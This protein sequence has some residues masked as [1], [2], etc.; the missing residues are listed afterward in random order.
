MRDITRN[1]ISTLA[2]AGM[3]LTVGCL[4]GCGKKTSE[5]ENLT[6]EVIE[7]PVK[8]RRTSVELIR[9]YLTFTGSI[10]AVQRAAIA[11]AMP[12]KIQ[13]IFVEEGQ[14]VSKGT[15]LV[16]MDD[17]QLI[18]AESRYLT[19]KADYERMRALRDNGSITPQQLEQIEAG[20]TAAKAAWEMTMQS[21]ILEAPFSG[22]IIGKYYNNEEIYSGMKPTP[23][24]TGA[25]VSLAQL[26][27]MKIEVNVPERDFPKISKG[28][29]ALVEL[30]AYPDRVFEGKVTGI[31]AAL[32][33]RSRAAKV[34]VE[35]RN[36]G[37]LLKPGMF[38]KI[39]IIM[40]EKSNALVVPSSAI[41][42]RE[43]EKSVFVVANGTSPFSTKTT[44][45]KVTTGIVTLDYSEITFGIAKG[46][47]VVYEGNASLDNGTN[48]RVIEVTE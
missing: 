42:S 28:Q 45:K 13:R 48:V 14:T 46:D 18:Q 9:D 24:G 40:T 44:L 38:A 33:M 47:L 27:A 43:G 30:E 26:D 5:K 35:I 37:R 7:I 12:G 1:G 16:K 39:K 11:P 15:I 29:H 41:V 8:A 23:D 22:T 4:A 36:T 32:D 20:Y 17:K 2:M 34:K 10:D 6:M 3:I 19:V 25:I 31:N 21:A